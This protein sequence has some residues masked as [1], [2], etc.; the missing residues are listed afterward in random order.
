[1]IIVVSG[2]PR[3]GTSMMM[4]ML[5]EAGVS[6]LSDFVRESD[7]DNID[8]YYEDERVKNLHR[9]NSWICEAE[10]K[11]VK[12]VSNLLLHLPKEHYYSII[13][14]DRNIDE[15]LASQRKMLQ[16]RNES[17][18]VPDSVM[19]NVYEKHLKEIKNWLQNQPNMKIL[20]VNYNDTLVNPEKTA[21]KVSEFL[22]MELDVEKMMKTVN[23]Q[24]Y[25]QRK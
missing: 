9:E 25:R 15:V 13:F 21:E 2:L 10:S 4:K 20:Y 6:I 1:M 11:A 18:E 3:S 17:Q 14:M 5:S 19:K 22:Q 7:E 24:R 12:V 23:P 8:G 16:R